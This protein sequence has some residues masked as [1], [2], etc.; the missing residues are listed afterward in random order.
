MITTN[1]HVRTTTVGGIQDWCI[2][3]KSALKLLHVK[4]QISNVVPTLLIHVN[5]EHNCMWSSCQP[6]IQHHY[7]LCMLSHYPEEKRKRMLTTLQSATDRVYQ[8]SH[9]VFSKGHSALWTCSS[10]CPLANSYYVQKLNV[11]FGKL[12]S[13]VLIFQSSAW[14]PS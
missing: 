7:N 4:I 8:W 2:I 14:G 11:P 5:P 13:I 10:M 12:F 3:C 6:W 1:V 9:Y